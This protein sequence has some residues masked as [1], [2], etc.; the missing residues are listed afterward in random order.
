MRRRRLLAGILPVLLLALT[1][2]CSGAGPGNPAS[3]LDADAEGEAPRRRARQARV[4]HPGEIPLLSL[5]GVS[6]P[7]GEQAG[8]SGGEESEE[9]AAGQDGGEIAKASA[10]KEATPA[11]ALPPRNLFAFEEDPAVVAER[12]RQAEEAAKQAAEAAKKAAEE[13]AKRDEELRLHPPPPQPPGITFQYVGYFGPADGRIGVFALPGSPGVFLSKAGDTVFDKFKI[14]D[15]GYESAEIG[16][17]GFKET[18]RI[19]L[20]GGGK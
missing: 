10:E 19:P 17:V 16:F 3:R 2:A 12:Q 1:W 6:V 5:E 15:V 14:V 11:P 7:G 20:V 18:K 4:V 13:R 9:A 8:T